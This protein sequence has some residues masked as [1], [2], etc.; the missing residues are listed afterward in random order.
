M[1]FGLL[2]ES[3]SHSKSP[4]IFRAGY[5]DRNDTYDL[6][7]FKSIEAGIDYAKSNGYSGVNITSPFKEI[8]VNIADYSEELSERSRAS[9]LLLFRDDKIYAYNTDYF[10]V[11]ESLIDYA[12]EGMRAVILGCGG[13]GRVAAIALKDMGLSV[14]ISNR[15]KVTGESFAKYADVDYCKISDINDEAKGAHIIVDTIPVKHSFLSEF[16]FYGKIVL[17]A[18]YKNPTLAKSVKNDKGKY[19]SGIDWLVNQAIPSFKL[20]TGINPNIEAIENLASKW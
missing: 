5:P 10:G 18:R 20:F 8:A 13:A 12:K 1:K 6:L 19:L 11:R 14:I 16:N 17:E 2:G 4:L 9:N 15:E 3:I 7:D